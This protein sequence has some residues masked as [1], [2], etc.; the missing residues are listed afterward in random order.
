MR[1][2][3]PRSRAAR[4]AED[5]HVDARGVAPAVEDDGRPPDVTVVGLEQV[6]GQPAAFVGD[7]DPLERR[8]EQ[9]GGLVPAGLHGGVGVGFVRPGGRGEDKVQAQVV[10]GG[11]PQ[12]GAAGAGP[13]P[14]LLFLAAEL[15]QPP[16]QGLELVVIG[17]VGR[18]GRVNGVDRGHDLADLRDP[19]SGAAE[20][21]EGLEVQVSLAE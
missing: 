14:G 3:Y 7:A 13:V 4:P 19:V 15:A 8:V 1:A 2:L 16:G 17:L 10:V 11:G 12:V 5:V 9:P 18:P 21:D 6:P 20:D